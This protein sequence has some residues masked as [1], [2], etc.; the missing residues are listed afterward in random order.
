MVRGIIVKGMGTTETFRLIPLT[1][2]RRI[3][4]RR[5]GNGGQ[6]GYGGQALPFGA[7]KRAHGGILA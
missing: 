7:T 2:L 1:R 6:D 5:G 4:L 3:L